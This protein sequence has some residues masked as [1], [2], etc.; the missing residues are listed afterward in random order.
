MAAVEGGAGHKKERD[1]RLLVPR[2]MAEGFYPSLGFLWTWDS[3]LRPLREVKRGLRNPPK[4]R[5][6]GTVPKTISLK[7]YD[8]P[9]S[10]LISSISSS[11]QRNKRWMS[12]GDIGHEKK[13]RGHVAEG[14]ENRSFLSH[15]ALSP[16]SFSF[17]TLGPGLFFEFLK[18]Q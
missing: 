6:V 2:H 10:L 3:A 5:E 9:N 8:G 14:P 11:T 12:G 4:E 1:V 15:M 18:L 13:G 7:N 16:T 17:V